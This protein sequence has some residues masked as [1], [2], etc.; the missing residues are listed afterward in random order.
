MESLTRLFFFNGNSWTRHKIKRKGTNG[1][2]FRNSQEF[3][4]SS[5]VL[6]LGCCSLSH[7]ECVSKANDYFFKKSEFVSG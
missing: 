2:N 7:L 3:A 6:L 4:L 5:T 1:L